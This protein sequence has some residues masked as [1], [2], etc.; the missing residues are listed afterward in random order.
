MNRADYRAHCEWTAGIRE[1]QA[2]SGSAGMHP[3]HQNRRARAVVRRPV[4]RQGWRR[5]AAWVAV[6]VIL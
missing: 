1:A 3:M 5:W 6:V 4:P 2:A